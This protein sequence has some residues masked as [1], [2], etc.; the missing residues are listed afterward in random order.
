MNG[1]KTKG[2]SGLS[3]EADGER[4]AS[5]GFNEL[6]AAKSKNFLRIVREIFREPMFLLLIAA[7]ILYLVLGDYKEGIVM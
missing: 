4:L 3:S 6:P 2:Y 7:G 1:D 5:G